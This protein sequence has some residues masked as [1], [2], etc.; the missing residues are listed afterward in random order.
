MDGF[1]PLGQGRSENLVS[2]TSTKIMPEKARI[3]EAPKSNNDDCCIMGIQKKT[4][5][6]S[7]NKPSVNHCTKF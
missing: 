3:L 7:S 2:P 4:I 1:E 6:Q 5:N